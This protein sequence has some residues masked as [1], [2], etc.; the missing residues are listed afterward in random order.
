MFEFLVSFAG[1][2]FLVVILNPISNKI[3][4]VDK[5]S[6]RK[7]HEG[8]IPLI[9]G[10]AMFGSCS[11]A[12][13]FYVPGS[14]EMS[15]LL[16]ACG[17]LVMT[18]SIDDRFDL[19]YRI[20]LASQAVAT[21]LLVF[22]ADTH[23]SSF[24]NILGYGEMSLGLFS[25]PITVLAVIGMVNAFNMIDGIDGLSGGIG[26]ISTTGLYI[27]I[28]DII[29][30]G[31]ENILILMMGA[32]SAYLMLNLHFFPKWTPKIFM[33]D[34]GSMVLGF[35]IVTFLIKYSQDSKVII[36]P[37]TALWIVAVPLM[38]IIATSIRRIRHGKNPFHPD[39]THVHHIFLRAGFSKR[40]TL[41]SIL[42]IQLTAT[43]LG[44]YFESVKNSL[45]SFLAFMIVYFI[46][47]LAIK[48]AFKA[49]KILRKIRNI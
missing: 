27:L 28:G 5:P 8:D 47:L 22:G 1:F 32:L 41:L 16:A 23:L 38:D 4:L 21:C 37:V 6:V 29:S 31:A 12:A 24:G 20:R 2:L 26:L 11:L 49:A 17:L 18:G 48:H 46:Y 30:D 44:I 25:I 33:G 19:H 3:G 7:Q 42:S 10:L 45:F 39:R 15:Y 9:G 43:L 14:N 13:L 34:A 35:V 40:F 36:M